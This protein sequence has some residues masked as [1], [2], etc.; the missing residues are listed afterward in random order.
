MFPLITLD[1]LVQTPGY[2]PDRVSFTPSGTAN[3]FFVERK[4]AETG[5]KWN[6]AMSLNGSSLSGTWSDASGNSDFWSW[7]RPTPEQQT[8]LQNHFGR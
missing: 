3:T 1:N 8:K 5:D 2:S 4:F 6:G 7:I